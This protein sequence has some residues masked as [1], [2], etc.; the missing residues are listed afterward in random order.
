MLITKTTRK[1]T[2]DQIINSDAF[3]IRESDKYTVTVRVAA[4]DDKGD[5]FHCDV[6]ITAS[7]LAMMQERIASRTE[8]R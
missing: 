4:Y 8:A 7:E 3:S 5:P 6:T 1:R 2:A